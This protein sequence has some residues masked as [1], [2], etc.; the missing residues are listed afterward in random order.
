MWV[1]YYFSAFMLDEWE[2]RLYAYNNFQTP[3]ENFSQ[4]YP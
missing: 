2:I 1:A 4:D 3:M